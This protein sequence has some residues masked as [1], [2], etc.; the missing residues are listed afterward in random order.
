MTKEEMLE[1]A[2]KDYPR[3]TKYVPVNMYGREYPDL[4][5]GNK[6]WRIANKDPNL[7]SDDVIDVGPGFIFA[8]DR[9][10]I[11]EDTELKDILA[12]IYKD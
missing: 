10:A 2:R 4:D 9:W 8:K 6:D 3:G 7:Y 1:K 11:R 12:F 5:T